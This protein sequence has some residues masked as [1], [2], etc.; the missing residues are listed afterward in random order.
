MPNSTSTEQTPAD[1]A[2]T[3]AGNTGN[4]NS[5]HLTAVSVKLPPYWPSDPYVWF[6]QVEAQFA[7]K[8]F[9]AEATK[10]SYVVAALTP[11]IAQEVHDILLA[12]PADNPYK[13]LREELIKRTS[14]TEQKRL[15]QLL[16]EEVLG[17]RKPTQF[18]RHM[19]KLLGDRVLDE[20]I[21]RQLFLQRLPSNVQM[22]LASTADKMKLE[23]LAELADKIMD[24][25]FH[26]QPAVNSMTPPTFSPSTPAFTPSTPPAQPSEIEL[27][28]REISQLS[29]QVNA[30]SSCPRSRSRSRTRNRPP[31]PQ[32]TSQADSDSTS[33]DWCWYH[34]SF[35]DK[36]HK[37]RQPCKFPGNM[38]ASN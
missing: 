12:P 23:P 22:V 25:A 37:C 18:L 3:S 36:A 4:D 15:Q 8:H 33:A 28:R 29:F 19:R 38:P 21:I 13:T 17:D 6:A 10:Y 24:V 2:S 30:L 32:S 1:P 31:T 5:G 7:T 34:A 9:T 35:G 20:S 16:N 11:D 27:L 26:Q 14:A